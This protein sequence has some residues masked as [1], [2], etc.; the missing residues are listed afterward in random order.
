MT[1]TLVFVIFAG[2]VVGAITR[3]VTIQRAELAEARAKKAQACAA[4]RARLARIEE[5]RAKCFRPD[6]D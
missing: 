5:F 2:L 4:E 1:S 6:G 3:M